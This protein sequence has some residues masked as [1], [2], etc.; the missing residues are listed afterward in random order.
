MSESD[1]I[2]LPLFT[3]T[4]VLGVDIGHAQRDEDRTEVR[5]YGRD[6]GTHPQV[7][8]ELSAWARR[9]LFNCTVPRE[10]TSE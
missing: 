6:P 4:E 2:N 7:F 10:D 9:N 8:R 5:V 3:H 1:R